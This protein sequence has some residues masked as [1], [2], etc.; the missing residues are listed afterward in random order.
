MTDPCL[1]QLPYADDY[2]RFFFPALENVRNTGKKLL[3]KH[4]SIPTLEQRSIIDS[5][6]DSL[7][8][9]AYD[10]AHSDECVVLSLASSHGPV[11]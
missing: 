2:R 5:L 11:A 10:A 3:E 4:T 9:S 8:L 1:P 7:N 6:V